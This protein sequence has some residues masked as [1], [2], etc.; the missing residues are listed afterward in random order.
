VEIDLDFGPLIASWRFLL[1]GLGL[2]LA[3]SALTVLCS[4]V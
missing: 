4:L 1:G 3:L 2:T